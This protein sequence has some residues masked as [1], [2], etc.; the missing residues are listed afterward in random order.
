MPCVNLRSLG[1]PD[2]APA[3]FRIDRFFNNFRDDVGVC[4][5]RSRRCQSAGESYPKSELHQGCVAD[6][7]VTSE[8]PDFLGPVRSLDTHTIGG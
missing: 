6:I 7:G 2:D 5:S 3:R 1:Q 4:R 8:L